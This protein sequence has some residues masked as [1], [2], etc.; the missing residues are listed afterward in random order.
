MPYKEVV[1]MK[2]RRMLIGIGDNSGSLEGYYNS[3]K[4]MKREYIRKF[5]KPSA[6]VLLY[7]WS[8]VKRKYINTIT[9][10]K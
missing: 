10:I 5:G 4:E 2:A 8:E 1:N 9:S 3:V 6:F 7:N